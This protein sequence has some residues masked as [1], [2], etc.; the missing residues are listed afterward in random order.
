MIIITSDQ[1]TCGLKENHFF[2]KIQIGNNVY[3]SEPKNI[4]MKKI[5]KLTLKAVT[6]HIKDVARGLA[7]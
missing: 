2:L 3:T 4:T 7:W 5:L 1:L 6:R